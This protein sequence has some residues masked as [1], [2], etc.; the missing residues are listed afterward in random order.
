MELK[1]VRAN[2]RQY[3]DIVVRNE[4]SVLKLSIKVRIQYTMTFAC[5]LARIDPYILE[6][7]FY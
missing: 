1:D 4:F 2:E 6:L 5:I 7:K 3:T